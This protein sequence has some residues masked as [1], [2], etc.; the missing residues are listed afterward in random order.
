MEWY[1]VFLMWYGIE[2]K[3]IYIVIC[4]VPMYGFSQGKSSGREMRFIAATF[5]G[6]QHWSTQIIMNNCCV[7]LTLVPASATG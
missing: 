3:E 5:N 4:F 7:T 6:H 1:G 2:Q